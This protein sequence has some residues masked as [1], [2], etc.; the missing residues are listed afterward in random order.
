MTKTSMI[1]TGTI[2]TLGIYDLYAVN[3]GGV[4]TSISRFLQNSALDAP[5]IA[6]CFGFICGHIFGYLKPK[7]P[8]CRKAESFK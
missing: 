5:L 6:F 2:I 1:V 4:D 3:F 7:C 8:V